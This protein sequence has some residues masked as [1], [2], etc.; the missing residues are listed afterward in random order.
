MDKG[1]LGLKALIVLITLLF[2]APASRAAI[3]FAEDDGDLLVFFT[4]EI[5]FTSFTDSTSQI[6]GILI[7]DA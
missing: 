3:L 2:T 7:A 5:S 4:E 1:Y 6:F